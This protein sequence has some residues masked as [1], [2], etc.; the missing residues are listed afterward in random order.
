MRMVNQ[1][2]IT[3]VVN[4]E[5]ARTELSCDTLWLLSRGRK[6][7]DGR[8]LTLQPNARGEQNVTVI[9]VFV[10]VNLQ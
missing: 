8:I 3:I 10:T 4:A 9:G 1:C 5:R 7:Y 2:S 6:L